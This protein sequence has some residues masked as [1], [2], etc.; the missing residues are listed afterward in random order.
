[1]RKFPLLNPGHE[2]HAAMPLS[3]RIQ[4]DGNGDLALA[5]SGLAAVRADCNP[6]SAIDVRFALF[7][8][9]FVL[10]GFLAVEYE[11][12]LL[13]WLVAPPHGLWPAESPPFGIRLRDGSEIRSKV[14][15]K[16]E[17]SGVERIVDDIN[18]LVNSI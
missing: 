17:G 16:L 14:E 10:V 3:S 18:V 12:R 15:L 6:E 8:L 4:F 1:M 9:L 11:L 7:S 5:V 2:V 13:Q